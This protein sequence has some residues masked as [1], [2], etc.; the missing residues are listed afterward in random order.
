MERHFTR[1]Y[2]RIQIS[3]TAREMGKDL[4]MTAEGGVK[5]IGSVVLSEPRPSLTGHASV[6]CTSSVINAIGHKDE[7]VC[8]YLA[9]ASASRLNRRT[10]CV[11]GI[12]YDSITEEEI[13]FVRKAA[14]EI[15]AEIVQAFIGV[16][17]EALS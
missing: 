3:V 15:A 7:A 13:Q 9:E 1:S 17:E 11:G 16:S 14:E 5:H 2:G 12:H 6:S 8:R 10:V 4:L